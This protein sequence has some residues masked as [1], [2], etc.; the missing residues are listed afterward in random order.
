MTD[1]KLRKIK[2]EAQLAQSI[3]MANFKKTPEYQLL[4]NTFEVLKL[5]WS[6]ERLRVMKLQSTRDMCLYFTGKEDA[7]QEL[8]ESI[9]KII[10]D[11]EDL[12]RTRELVSQYEG[13]E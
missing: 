6:K 10:S 12:R 7:V 5:I 4:R 9:D 13:G 3:M 8:L 11:G 2:E 1:E